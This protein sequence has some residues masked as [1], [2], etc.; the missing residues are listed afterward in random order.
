MN[1]V[2]LDFETANYDR[3][4]ACALGIVVVE[5]G[6][7]VEQKTWLIKPL[8]FFFQFTYIHGISEKDT[9]NSP[10]FQDLWYEILDMIN[11]QTVI[12]HNA[13]FD[14]GVIKALVD[15]HELP[16]PTINYLCTV[17][18]ARRT[19]K[20]LSHYNL[21]ALSDKFQIP[22]QHHN[23]LSDT[24]ACAK[25]MLEAKQTLQINTVEELCKSL[26]MKPKSFQKG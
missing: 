3:K 10:T 19:W 5:N 21:K 17:Q 1:F 15:Y 7:I 20:G 14:I 2:A 18:I 12:A 8:P 9:H 22:L 4:S 16:Q 13:N 6:Q 25:I 23:A 24:L 26:N 11:Y